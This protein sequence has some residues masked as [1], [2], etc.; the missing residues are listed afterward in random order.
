MTAPGEVTR[1]AG[2]A[3]G[4]RLLEAT[5]LNLRFG[6]VHSLAGVDL[7]LDRGE[8]L[9]VIG[10]NGAGK[11]SLF[12][13]LT[14]VYRPQTGSI[15]YLTKTGAMLDVIGR[16]PHQI[17]RLGVARTFQNIRLF[18]ALTALENV[19]VGVEAGQHTGP[20]AAML[21]MPWARREE[22]ES[23]DRACELLEF[24]GLTHRTNAVASSLP[25]GEQRRL[26]I[27]RGLAT[28]PQILLLDEPAAGTNPSEKR[29]LE[30][31]ISSIHRRDV[32]VLLIEHDMR[33]V[34]SVATRV[35]VLNFG[36]V[37]AA[38]TPEQVQRDPAVIE[39]YLGSVDDENGA[40]DA[41]HG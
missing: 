20:V 17:T 40:G 24:V 36:R 31:L 33:L 41:A 5:G 7:A 30:A 12:N 9:A 35:V 22:R 25:Y 16:K 10:P 14:G 3:D 26:E 4:T 29:D 19:K 8:V 2:A 11:T 37:I 39:A 38:G 18:A 32:S 34:M 6:G 1:E 27:A 13:C 28:D 15:R 21:G 23:N